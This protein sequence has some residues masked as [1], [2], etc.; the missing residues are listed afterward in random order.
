MTDFGDELRRLL[1]EC[2]VSLTAA[3]R[4]A[5]CSKGYLSNAANGRKPLTPTVAAG[6]DRLFGT[7]RHIRCLRPAPATR[8]H[9]A[10]KR[11]PAACCR[12][13]QRDG[14]R[15]YPQRGT[16]PYAGGPQRLRE[17]REDRERC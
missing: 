8:R 10:G 5:E 11:L 1:A 6:L 7:G 4:R 17:R 3:A 16:G 2:G 15:R 9:Q 14:G 12:R 13:G